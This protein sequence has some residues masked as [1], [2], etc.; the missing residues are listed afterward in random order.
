[1]IVMVTGARG[2]IGSRLVPE[3]VRAG[4]AVMRAVRRA[5]VA[6][7]EI[8]WTPETGALEPARPCDAVIHLAGHSLAAG[9]W[10]AR[11]K[12][13]A[14]SSRVDGTRA[15][16]ERLAASSTPPRVFVSASG[17]GIY[18]DRGDER[19]DEASAAAADFLG[20]LAQA[21]EAGSQPLQ[22]AGCRTVSLR[23]GLVLAREGGALPPLL[24]AARLGLGGRLGS[25]RQYWSWVAIED[26]V[27]VFRRALERPGLAGAVNVVA[28]EPVRQAEFARVLGRLLRRPAWFPTPA[29]VLRSVLGEM[30]EATILASARVRPRRLEEDGYRFRHPDLEKA[31]EAILAARPVDAHRGRP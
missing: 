5:P 23:L 18:G 10:T 3:L 25:G 14:W 28:P 2:L 15:L 1:M 16:C 20:E 24:L 7:D 17:I 27:A 26:V 9:R 22:R 19:L 8:Q 4:H 21:W 6:S 30:A 12:Q 31:L 13:R 11:N 29:L